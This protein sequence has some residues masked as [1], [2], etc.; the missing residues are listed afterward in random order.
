MLTIVIS[1]CAA[2]IASTALYLVT[3]NVWWSLAVAVVLILGLN[4][5]LG[6]HFLNKLKEL[7]ASVE[8]D[9]RAGR[10]EKAIEKLQSG[11]TYAKWQFFVKEQINSQIGI[12][13]YSTRKFEEAM[14]YLEKSFSKNW[15]SVSMLAAAYYKNK[16]TDKV[17]STL[18]K[19]IKDAPKEGFLYSF[20]AW[21]LVQENQA[22]KAI[23]VLNKGVAKNPLDEKLEAN[24][25]SIKNGK[26]IKMERYGNVWL[27]LQLTKLPEGGKPYQQ[28]LANQRV[29][30]R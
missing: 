7:F 19:G 30:R 15:M 24:L 29:K 23:E 26:K 21:V 10:N 20:Y 13:L 22:D 1:V 6:R 17:L 2:V 25:E 8:K 18:A 16:Q 28:F 9:L 11:Y 12:I 14:P 3:Y 27:Q 4:F 5:F